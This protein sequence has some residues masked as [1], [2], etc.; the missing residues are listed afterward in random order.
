MNNIL[1]KFSWHFRNTL[2]TSAENA[3]LFGHN[4][5][6]PAHILYSLL[7]ERG[8]V[9]A[10]LLIGLKLDSEKVKLILETSQNAVFRDDAPLPEFSEPAKKIIEKAVKSAY[11]NKHKYIGTEHLLSALIESS[12][13]LISR[14]LIESGIIQ[15]HL[16]KQT[17]S[18]L[19]SASK[20][21]D[22][23]ENFKENSKTQSEDDEKSD[24]SGAL[25]F[26]GR[27][28]CEDKIQ[29]GIDPVIGREKEISRIIEILSR[30]GKNNPLLLGDP[31]VGKTA[32]IEGLAKKIHEGKVPDILLDKKIYTLDLASI[33]AGTSYRGEFEARLKEIIWEAESRPEVILFI[34]EIHQ[35][36]GAGSAS[37]SLDAANVLKPALARAS[38]HVIGATTFQDF[39][40]SLEND[41]ALTR[42]F[43]TIIIDEP[44]SDTAKDMLFGIKK[45]FEDFHQVEIIDE[46]VKTAVD[47]SQKYLPEKFLPDKAIDL[48]DEAAA[49]LKAN[50]KPTKTEQAVKEISADMKQLEN[51]LHR[52]ILAENFDGAL[53]I[54]NS[55][56]KVRDQVEK[57]NARVNNE[58]KLVRGQVNAEN[59]AAIVA[60]ITG[61][62]TDD[63]LRPEI[64]KVLALEKELKAE[65]IGQDKAL[66]DLGA[67]LKR[68]KAGL[69]PDNR[70]LASFM[71]VGPSGV[72][73]TH[74]AKLLAK[75]F[76][77][78]EK[79]L[80][81]IDMSEYGEKFNVSKLI[82]APAGYVGYKESGQL[83]EKIKHRPYSLVLFDEIEKANPEIFDLL[84]SVLEDGYLTDAAGSKIN[85]QNIIIIMTSNLGSQFYGGQSH[86][87]FGARLPA[88][89]G[90]A[91][92]GQGN[93]GKD[94]AEQK[95]LG[96]VKR[97]FKP[98]F[99]NRLD[100][101]I[102][103]NN[104][105]Q[106]DLEK[107]VK[108]ELDKLIKKIRTEKSIALNVSSNIYGLLAQQ[109]QKQ[110]E[111]GDNRGARQIRT[112]IRDTVETPLADALL[113]KKIPVGKT[114]R[115]GIKNGIITLS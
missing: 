108:L 106:A 59:I 30:R 43:Q 76:F 39:R 29:S 51:D 53:N 112:V 61:I 80:I 73:K 58:K 28:L 109:V 68:A 11:L 72:G 93:A 77:G 75:K 83:T 69:S 31:G 44:S 45:Y 17:E 18:I 70:P 15:S 52:L 54:K 34:D 97:W 12:D 56:I 99:L 5:V 104:L 113:R 35:I 89:E 67:Y 85:F 100:K 1:E 27:N 111:S 7:E 64:K 49:G 87:G 57:L 23:L 60:K 22:V 10:E 21:P 47:L 105:L 92:C 46:A 95:V 41:P 63:L 16:L 14:I 96:E 4:L 115:L 32:I 91:D 50:R 84:L 102:C 26:F 55:I 103:F 98:E 86:I 94:S 90:A 114:L 82:G 8:S 110:G 20:L 107:I 78:D 3:K 74:T 62:P 79:A 66:A 33:I 71:F 48:I 25:D 6:E 81:K 24:A 36:V 65:I 9:G 88:L 38:L 37:G 101:I 19:K 13:P 2:R 42:R 40:K